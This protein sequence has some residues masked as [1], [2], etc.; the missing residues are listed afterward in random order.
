MNKV[1][2]SGR[3]VADPELKTTPNGVE[4]TTFRI[5]VNR[6]YAKQG[7][8]RKTDFFN[9]VA[10]RKT[11]AF[12]CQY[13]HKGDGINLVG[14]LQS[15]QYEAK[16]GSNRYVVEVVAESVEFPLARKAENSS[17]PS[18]YAPPVQIPTAPAPTVDFQQMPLDDDLPF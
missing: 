17:A 15:R 11:A 4:T 1:I 3:I 12:I 6:D 13:F 7:E 10:W 18:T 5:A 14:N 16:D 9:V 8:E 2:L